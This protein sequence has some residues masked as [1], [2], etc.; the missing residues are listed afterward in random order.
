MDLTCREQQNRGM[1]AIYSGPNVGKRLRAVREALGLKQY[2][3][4]DQLGIERSALSQYEKG[5][6]SD[7]NDRRITIEVGIRFCIEYNISL[8][9]VYF[10]KTYLVPKEILDKYRE[11]LRKEVVKRG[12]AA[13]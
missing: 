11:L 4:A 3:V 2:E 10:G 7:G 5:L 8:D 1:A 13:G 12:R 6:D 9:W